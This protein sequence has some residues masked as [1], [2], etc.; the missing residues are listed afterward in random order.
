MLMSWKERNPESCI[1]FNLYK[2]LNDSGLKYTARKCFKSWHQFL[3]LFSQLT[4]TCSK[5]PIQAIE[6]GVKYL[7]WWLW[8]SKCYLGYVTWKWINKADEIFIFVQFNSGFGEYCDFFMSTFCII[9]FYVCIYCK[10]LIKYVDGII[11]INA[12]IRKVYG[13]SA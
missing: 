5:A 3:Y 13:R 12:L 4:F 9:W 8:I 10:Q 7:Y 11:M 2:V 1:P 6:K